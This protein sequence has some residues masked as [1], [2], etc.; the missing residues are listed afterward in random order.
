MSEIAR[1]TSIQARMVADFAQSLRSDGATFVVGRHTERGF[2]MTVVPD[3]S[4]CSD[5]T[6]VV[7]PVDTRFVQPVRPPVEEISIR[8]QGMHEPRSLLEFDAV[9]WTEA[10]V[11]KFLIPY[12]ASK[13]QWLAADALEKLSQVWYGCVP[14]PGAGPCPPPVNG[15]AEIPFAVGHLPRS[16]YVP[17]EIGD[18]VVCLFRDAQ[19]NVTA[20]PL[21]DFL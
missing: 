15:D 11:E 19:G 17:L 16:E 4:P 10:S 14:R 20:R 9:F 21:S 18:E 2:E 3:H 7:V 1:L 8:A 13:Y 12:L 5:E 6:H